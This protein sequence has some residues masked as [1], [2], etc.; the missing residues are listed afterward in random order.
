MIYWPHNILLYELFHWTTK[1]LVTECAKYWKTAAN[2]MRKGWISWPTNWR[3]QECWP[4]T[5]TESLTRWEEYSCTVS[6]ALDLGVL[7]IEIRRRYL[8]F[9][10]KR[11]LIDETR[12]RLKK[13]N[14]TVNGKYSNIRVQ[15]ICWYIFLLK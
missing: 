3:R 14:I 6:Y 9:Q 4:K 5:L 2:R 1:L 10:S 15:V 13:G 7:V 8:K 11:I 12:T